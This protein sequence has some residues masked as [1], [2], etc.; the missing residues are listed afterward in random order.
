MQ[1]Q[2]CN[3]LTASNNFPLLRI[4]SKSVLTYF[5]LTFLQPLSLY[6]DTLP[7]ILFLIHAKILLD[8]EP[9]IRLLALPRK[10]HLHVCFLLSLSYLHKPHPPC[11]TYFSQ[12]QR[13]L[14]PAFYFFTASC[15][16]NFIVH[17]TF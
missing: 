10:P 8:L 3:T 2:Q 11:Q 13:V 14:A 16:V 4:K 6:T 17:I 15:F 9:L 7:L 5:L 1:Q 12:K